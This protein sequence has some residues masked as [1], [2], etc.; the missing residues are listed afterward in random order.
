LLAAVHRAAA[1][2]LAPSGCLGDAAVNDDLFQDQADDAVIGLQRDLLEPGEDPGFDPFVAALPDRGGRAGTLGDRLIRQ[3]N[4]STW[5]SFS[6][7]MR[8][9]IR[10]RWQPSG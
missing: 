2:A 3:P 6:K 8:S 1:G 7:M 10:G 4:R 5:I 9:G